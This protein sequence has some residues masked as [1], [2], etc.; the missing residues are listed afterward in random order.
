MGHIPHNHTHRGDPVSDAKTPATVPLVRLVDAPKWLEDA[1]RKTGMLESDIEHIAVA[2]VL[3]QV[4]GVGVGE[5]AAG[6]SMVAQANTMLPLNL[7]EGGERVRFLE[8]QAAVTA[9]QAACGLVPV[10]F[11]LLVVDSRKLKPDVA[12]TID[13]RTKPAVGLK[14]EDEP[15]FIPLMGLGDA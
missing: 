7:F 4:A 2:S 1:L 15:A 3:S 6:L 5:T 10:V 12:A 14:S 11:T 8:P 9:A 13:S